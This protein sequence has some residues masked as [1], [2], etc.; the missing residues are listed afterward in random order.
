MSLGVQHN[1][2]ERQDIVGSE[3]EVE[4]LECFGLWGREC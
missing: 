2:V 4:V 3:E 1:L